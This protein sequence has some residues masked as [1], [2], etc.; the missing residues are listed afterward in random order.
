V[1]FKKISPFSACNS[2]KIYIETN[3]EVLENLRKESNLVNHLKY[4]FALNFGG[5]DSTF[6]KDYG[7]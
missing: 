4:I 2:I 1:K 3:G 6:R 5:F 7:Y